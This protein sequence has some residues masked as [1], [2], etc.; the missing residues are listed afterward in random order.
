VRTEAGGDVRRLRPAATAACALACACAAVAG[1]AA[2]GTGARGE[3]PAPSPS[4]RRSSTAV[5][6]AIARDPRAVAGMVRSD[7]SVSERVRRELAPCDDSR[8]PVVTDA[9]DLTAGE[10]PDLVVNVMTCQD[11]VGVAAYVYREVNGKYENVFADERPPVYGNVVGGRLEIIHEVYQVDDPDLVPTGQDSAVYAWRTDC[12]VQ[13]TRT[14]TDFGGRT[15]AARP[16]PTSTA[17]APRPDAGPV[18]PATVPSAS[19][20][21]RTG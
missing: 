4:A 1:C 5:A 16:E 12:F 11:G 20:A 14:Y 3:G 17:P 6:P 2:D 13:V 19:A 18:E 10:G 21:V 8:Y 15:P 9:G 7:T